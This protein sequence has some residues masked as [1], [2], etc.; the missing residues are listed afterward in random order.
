MTEQPEARPKVYIVVE[1]RSPF[2]DVTGVLVTVE[3]G[4][5][6]S[7]SSSDIEWLREIIEAPSVFDRQMLLSKALLGRKAHIEIHAGQTQVRADDVILKDTHAGA[8]GLTLR[9]G[10]GE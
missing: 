1:G 2:G 8:S 10:V 6:W 4:P 9:F 3:D 7:H 5:L